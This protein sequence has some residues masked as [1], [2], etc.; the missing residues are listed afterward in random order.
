MYK[1]QC[2]LCVLIDAHT[3]PA[4]H[5]KQLNREADRERRSKTNEV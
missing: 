3:L 4:G 5:V 1:T 2:V